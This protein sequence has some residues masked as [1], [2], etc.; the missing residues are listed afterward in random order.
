MNTDTGTLL[1]SILLKLTLVLMALVLLLDVLWAKKTSGLGWVVFTG[2]LFI[3]LVSLL[4]VRFPE[5]GHPDL[6]RYAA[7]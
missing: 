3:I 6:G 7:F 5:E 4:V 1:F 2:L